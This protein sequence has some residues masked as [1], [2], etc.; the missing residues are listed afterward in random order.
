MKSRFYKKL[1][2]KKVTISKYI[3]LGGSATPD[4]ESVPTQSSAYL[5]PTEL[6]VLDENLTISGHQ[7]TCM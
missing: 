1:N 5:E 3:I 4:S 2:L 6:P 7:Q